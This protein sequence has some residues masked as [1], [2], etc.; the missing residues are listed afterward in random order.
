[1]LKQKRFLANTPEEARKMDQA[2]E[3]LY[4][5]GAVN[6]LAEQFNQLSQAETISRREVQAKFEQRIQAIRTLWQEFIDSH[7]D[8]ARKDSL[9]SGRDRIINRLQTLQSEVNAQLDRLLDPTTQNII[10]SRHTEKYQEFLQFL[11]NKNL[12]STPSPAPAPAPSPAPTPARTTPPSRPSIPPASVKRFGPRPA[13]PRRTDASPDRTPEAPASTEV[14]D[15]MDL[16]RKDRPASRPDQVRTLAREREQQRLATGFS[17]L[18]T[19]WNGEIPAAFTNGFVERA[20]DQPNQRTLEFLNKSLEHPDQFKNLVRSMYEVFRSMRYP[21]VSPTSW[22]FRDQLRHFYEQIDDD[23]FT[24]ESIQNAMRDLRQAMEWSREMEQVTETPNLQKARELYFKIEQD[25]NARRLPSKADLRQMQKLVSYVETNFLSG[26]RLTWNAVETAQRTR[27]P[28]E[29]EAIDSRVGT[30]RV[31]N[32]TKYTLQG[33]TIEVKNF[34]TDASRPENVQ[35]ISKV[36]GRTYPF[37]L[38]HFLATVRLLKSTYPT[39]FQHQERIFFSQLSFDIRN[40]QGQ[41]RPE[42]LRRLHVQRHQSFLRSLGLEGDRN[43]QY[44]NFPNSLGVM[45]NV[46]DPTKAEDLSHWLT[47]ID[48][49]ALTRNVEQKDYKFLWMVRMYARTRAI[50]HSG[51]LNLQ[52]FAEKLLTSSENRSDIS[53]PDKN[54]IDFVNNTGKTPAEKARINAEYDRYQNAVPAIKDIFDFLTSLP[55]NNDRWTGNPNTT[56]ALTMFTLLEEA[57][58][59]SLTSPHVLNG[60]SDIAFPRGRD[61]VLDQSKIRIEVG[62]ESLDVPRLFFNADSINRYIQLKETNPFFQEVLRFIQGLPRDNQVL[63]SQVLN[64]LL[65]PYRTTNHT[66]SPRQ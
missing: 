42:A 24:Q 28:A 57:A 49:V 44:E 30:Y 33:R 3:E 22:G 50:T 59:Q 32:N 41:E 66:P 58:Q 7:S 17:R 47:L 26:E 48:N 37:D 46:S 4:V 10:R 13:P 52:Q 63:F 38:S 11:R 45:L 43:Y 31:K 27:T 16:L 5:G 40:E 8:Q 64:S 65:T 6:T 29:A 36:G 14:T 12:L 60:D 56:P 39:S 25:I 23:R 62:N 18:A 53:A 61:N 19:S 1:M 34:Y 55:S 21:N 2:M 15:V 51:K 54:I 20:L 35:T 9:A